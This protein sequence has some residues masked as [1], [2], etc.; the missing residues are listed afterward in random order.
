MYPKLE[1][2]SKKLELSTSPADIQDFTKLVE[3][4]K[5]YVG[6]VEKLTVEVNSLLNEKEECFAEFDNDVPV[7]C[8]RERDIRRKQ[9]SLIMTPSR[10][11]K[12]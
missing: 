10:R 2:N 11:G 12:K 5:E 9:K 6:D 1:Q 7:V 8:K 4:I 3:G